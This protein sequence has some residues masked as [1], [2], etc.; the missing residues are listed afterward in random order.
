MKL[1]GSLIA[2]TAAGLMGGA[3]W[4]DTG[5]MMLPNGK[6]IF[7]A[8]TAPGPDAI[9]ADVSQGKYLNVRCGDVVTFTQGSQRFTWKFDATSH[10]QI[11]LSQIAPAGFEAGDYR[12][13]VS[14]NDMERGG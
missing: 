5:A 14:R 9:T 8:P 2:A 4:A 13:H 6:T 1:M 10:R 11:A 12:V 7:G 3:A